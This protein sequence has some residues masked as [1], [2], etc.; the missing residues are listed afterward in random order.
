VKSWKS[1]VGVRKER[2]NSAASRPGYR[3]QKIVYIFKEVSNR[4]FVPQRRDSFETRRA[5][6]EDVFSGESVRGRFS[7]SLRSA[8]MDVPERLRTLDL[9]RVLLGTNQKRFPLCELGVSA[10]NGINF[11]F[12]LILGE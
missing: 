10:V 8:A 3:E 9:P 7:R 12:L 5:Q 11:S 2:D 1:L 6:R 4:P